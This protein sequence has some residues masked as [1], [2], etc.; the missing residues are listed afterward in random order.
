[1]FGWLWRAAGRSVRQVIDGLGSV[2]TLVGP[3]A[4]VD[5][6]SGA[7]VSKAVRPSTEQQGQGRPGRRRQRVRLRVRVGRLRLR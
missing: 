3:K 5:A 7:V 1:M 4:E 2:G 6:R